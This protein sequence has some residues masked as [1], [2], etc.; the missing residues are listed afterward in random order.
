MAQYGPHDIRNIALVGPGGSGKTTLIEALLVQAGALPEAGS[1]EK[2]TT[3]CDFDP[4]EKSIQH[5]LEPAIV[6]LENAGCHI[7]LIDTPGMPDFLGRAVSILPAIETVAITIE[8]QYGVDITTTR[9]LE[10]AD[11][12]RAC[13]L[14]IINKI[15]Q[16]G[17]D[18]EAVMN[19][20]R[21]TLGPG[22]L[23]INLP[24]DQGRRV[25]DC[26]F[27]PDTAAQTDFSSVKA[28]HD[29]LIDQVVELDEALMERYLEQGQALDPQ[30]LHDPFE[31]ALR[32]RH[33]IP[34]CF[35]SAKT[36]AGLAQLL[37]VF[38]ELMPNPAEGNPP[39][40][41]KGEGETAKPVMV[42]PDPQQHVVAH[43][44]K[45][46]FDPFIG[47]LGIFRIH[48]GTITPNTQLFIGDA[49][50]PFKVSHLY[51]VHGKEHKEIPLGLP[52][53]ICA[54]TKVDELHF[55]AVLHDSHDEDHFH[56]RSIRCPAPMFG[57][58]VQVKKR[59]DEQKFSDAIHKIADE[60]PC[61]VIEQAKDANETVLRAVGEQH[62]RV[63]LDKLRERYHL[64]LEVRPPRIPYRETITQPAEG[65]ARHKKQTG[66]AG[67]FGEVFL[68]IEPL[69]RGEGFVFGNA[70]VGGAIPGQ[71]IPAVEKGVRQVLESGAI[72]GYP[73][74]DLKVTVYDGKYHAVDSKEIAFIAAAR[75]AFLDAIH[76]AKG[77]L[78][79]PVVNIQI[80]TPSSAVGSITGDLANLRGRIN[81]TSVLPD[82]RSIIDGQV[83]LSELDNYQS[84]LKSV[85]G[86][87]G[88]YTMEF[89]HYEA[90]PARIQQELIAAFKPKDDED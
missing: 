45:I 8:P 23:P 75:K 51:R 73:L 3:V 88:S 36:G 57:L 30:Q 55:D 46:S 4:L 37:R 68:R 53:D 2:G 27:A 15:E 52:G 84:K 34:I 69:P 5:S 64:E 82:G 21:D 62:L 49:R 39:P 43:V 28:A 90:V 67:Q 32:Q 40:F 60:D 35:V 18:W 74:Q 9:L 80:K 58:A 61:L 42:L 10:R 33:L 44:F 65:H 11:D 22:C 63:I 13:R 26:Y 19:R 20:L 16:P 24:A 38:C 76:K 66:G 25:V 50:K 77:V 71:F 85:T 70:V 29:A 86:G 59:G 48:Q 78:L 87:E 1:I 12:M 17:I 79:E 72:A 56:L 54:V 31:E 14:V 83:P 89:S 47:K 7:H 6:H 81:G 41:V